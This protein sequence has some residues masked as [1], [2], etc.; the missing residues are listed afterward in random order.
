MNR[1]V[2]AVPCRMPH[3]HAR[4]WG[5]SPPNVAARR[6]MLAG[7]IRLLALLAAVHACTRSSI[8]PTTIPSAHRAR[9]HAAG[10]DTARWTNKFGAHCKDFVTDGHCTGTGFAPGREWAAAPG[11]GAAGLHCCAW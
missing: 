9:T 3:P 4:T 10:T 6:A 2:Y 8:Y 7:S 11:F 1:F 5:P